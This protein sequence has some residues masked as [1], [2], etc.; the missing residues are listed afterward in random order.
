MPVQL[1]KP[2]VDLGIVISE[3]ERSLAF[4]CG[5]LGLE[6]VADIPMPV[7]GDGTMHR[8]RCGDTLL[9]LVRFDTT[10][11]PAAGGGIAGA[12]GYRYLTM[13]VSNLDEIMQELAD[14]GVPVAVPV[15]DL[16]PGVRIGMVEDPDGNWVEF[17]ETS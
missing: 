7:G 16:R 15:T 4:Y 9:K 8:V 11:P 5:L 17:V 13:I 2:A 12:L 3:S 6:H 10:P 14:S 1:A